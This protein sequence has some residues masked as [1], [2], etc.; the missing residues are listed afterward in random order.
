LEVLLFLFNELS[1]VKKSYYET[2]GV[3][4]TA[5]NDE[6]KR[7][8]FGL[9]RKY[10]P[11]RSPQEF[12]EIRAA[13]ETLSDKQKRAEY[14]AIGELPSSVAPL[15]Y[16][17]QRFDRFGR[18]DKAA[19][20]YQT[21][22]ERYPDLDNVREQY[23]KSLMENDKPGKAVE[24]W[25]ELCHR[26]PGNAHYAREL[27]RGYFDRGWHKKAITEIRRS[28]TIDRGSIDAW[29]LLILCITKSMMKD[30]NIWDELEKV[31]TEAVEAV[32][33]VKTDEWKKIVL[34]THLFIDCG[35]NKITTAR[36]YL[37][38][39]IRIVRENGRKG[40]EEGYPALQ[41]ILYLIPG[42]SL[43]SLY[44][45]LKELSDLTSDM[46]AAP[47]RNKLDDIKLSLEIENLEEKGFHEI[48]RDLFRILTAEFEE[49]YDEIEILSIE[50]LLLK[51]KSI[52]DPQIRRLRTEFPELYFLHSSFF[53]ETLRTRNPDKMMYQRGKKVDKLKREAGIYDEDPDSED[54]VQQTI[55]RDQPKVGRND[56][57]PCGSGKKYKRCCGR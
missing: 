53:N 46:N 28:L 14:D 10:Q 21:I 15:F 49:D 18:G 50:Y 39:I 30:P 54:F 37:R 47:V 22:L 9:V 16:E 38:E 56:P 6:I 40:Q 3:A 1:E 48:F 45:D 57:C 24:V 36:G 52:F 42:R 41:Q 11:D 35:I 13:Y 27:S 26:Q 12:K 19:E 7:A 25:E 55:R 23:A 44:P 2:L 32:K 31:A 8:Y 34:Y 29:I 17:A 5:G 51:D 33:T 4:R 43:A 20:L